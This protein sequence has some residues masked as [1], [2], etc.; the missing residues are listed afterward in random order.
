[1]ILLPDLKMLRFTL[2]T[3]TL[4][5]FS[6]SRKFSREISAWEFCY[7]EAIAFTCD[8]NFTYVSETC[9]FTELYYDL[10][11]FTPDISDPGLFS[12]ISQF[13]IFKK[14]NEEWGMGNEVNHFPRNFA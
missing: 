2:E 1:M 7:N 13:K 12:T 11:R 3:D 14:W 4:N 6:N 9:D 10:R 8:C 5:K